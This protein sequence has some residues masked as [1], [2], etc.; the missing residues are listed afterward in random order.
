MGMD[1]KLLFVYN[2]H[3]G[4]QM[5]SRRLADIVDIFTKSGYDVTC[6]PTQCRTD[7]LNTVESECQKYDMTVISGGDGTLNEAVNGFMNSGCKKPFGYIPSGSTNDFSHSAGIP[8]K[9]LKAA[10]TAM[11]GAIFESDV[12]RLNDRYFTYVAGFG[13]LT[14]V[15][16]STPQDAKNALGFAAYILEGIAAV[17]AITSFNISYESAERCGSGEYLVGLI[18]NTVHV[19]GFKSLI[20]ES[21]FMD[22]GLFEVLLVKNPKNAADINKLISSVLKKQYDSEFIES[23]K[24]SKITV[25]SETPLAWT[26][27]GE[28]GGAHT[29]SVI[30]NYPRAL[31]VM[32]SGSAERLDTAK[33]ENE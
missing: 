15:S 23:F 17:P 21:V 6:H 18:T 12:G 14:E 4:K 9:P 11:N 26:L 16:Y 20:S 10:E 33:D 2:P 27:D 7:C 1:K 22:D 5:I 32:C 30:E 24:T 29:V 31:K 13:T 8:L 3:S 28:N 19:A 25:K